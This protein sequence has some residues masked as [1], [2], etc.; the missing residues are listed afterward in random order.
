MANARS[1]S[2]WDFWDKMCFCYQTP[3]DLNKPKFFKVY[4]RHWNSVS[5]LIAFCQESAVFSRFSVGPKS[6]GMFFVNGMEAMNR[7]KIKIQVT[8]LFIKW[9]VLQ[10]LK[11]IREAHFIFNQHKI[12]CDQVLNNTVNHETI[13]HIFDLLFIYMQKRRPLT[14]KFLIAFLTLFHVAFD[15]PP[16]SLLT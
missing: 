7:T 8:L 3:I 10:F 9:E 11:I 15:L 13:G 4:E 16:F 2:D 5:M 12:K 14:S 1:L 6:L